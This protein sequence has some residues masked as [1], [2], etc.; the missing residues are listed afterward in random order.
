VAVRPLPALVTR[1]SD[2]GHD[3]VEVVLADE[4][5]W[6]RYAAAHWRNLRLWLD[7]HP[8]DDLAPQ[9]RQ[10]LSAGPVRHVTYTRNLVGWGCARS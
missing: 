4:D 1:F 10:E 2:C 3:R 8:D 9:L 6:D 5:S 7:G